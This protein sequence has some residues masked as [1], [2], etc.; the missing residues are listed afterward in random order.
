MDAQDEMM[1][2]KMKFVFRILLEIKKFLSVDIELILFKPIFVKKF[3]ESIVMHSYSA[4]KWEIK[5]MKNFLLK[6]FS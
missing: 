5:G 1:D 4:S 2:S 3:F 6:I